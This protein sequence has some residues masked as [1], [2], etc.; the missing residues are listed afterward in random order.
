MP[1]VRVLSIEQSILNL[2]TR[3][4]FRYGIITLNAVP[5]LFLKA[6]VEIDGRRQVG[7]AADSLPPKWFTKDPDSSPRDD[8]TELLEVIES[9]CTIAR[10]VP[11]APSVFA[12]WKYLY[13][14]QAAW[15]G[16]WGKAPLLYHFGTSLVE[17]AVIDAVCKMMSVPFFQAVREGL[18]GIQLGVLQPELAGSSP[19]DWLPATPLREITARHTIGLVDYLTD[20]EVPAGERLDDGLPQSL[21]ACVRAYGLTQFKL[22]LWGDVP[23]DIER[24]RRVAEV[25]E[26]N[27]PGGQYA[28]TAD[29]NENFKAVEPFRDFWENLTV[30]PALA[31]FV[32]R[33]IFV[34]QPLHRA[35]ALSPEVGRALANWP[36]RPPL[37]IDE[38]DGQVENARAALSLGYAGT[39]HKNCK[40]VIKGIANRCLI[41]HR[42]R[43]SPGSRFLMSGEDLANV[44]P[45][46]LLQ[47]LAVVAAFGIA[48]VERNGHHYFRGLSALPPNVQAAVQRAHPDLYQMTPEHF[49][50]ARIEKGRMQ[51]GSVVDAPFGTAFA[52]DTSQFTPVSAWRW[53]TL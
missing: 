49:P 4:P 45:V 36:S 24:V 16:G 40:G 21:E 22:K 53:E 11:R 30:E 6:E 5:H 13:E 23:R 48:S 18:F 47:D 29:A 8:V 37:I 10:A 32:S 3:M 19:R 26:R 2:R 12:F 38:S 39:S 42:S 43:Q 17:R 31:K 34:E 25:V 50:T 52:L 15:G 44:G 51:T 35:M 33:V 27:V 14:M 20:E 1:A 9:A 28:F 7:I 41:K 46:A